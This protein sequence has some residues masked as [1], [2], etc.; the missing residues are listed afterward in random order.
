MRKEA[1]E[2]IKR[3]TQISVILD[4]VAIAASIPLAV[5]D[6]FS[7]ISRGQ[8]NGLLLLM[9]PFLPLFIA[10]DLAPGNLWVLGPNLWAML[11]AAVKWG[12]MAARGVAIRKKEA[13]AGERLDSYLSKS[14]AILAAVIFQI[15]ANVYMA[16]IMFKKKNAIAGEYSKWLVA[17]FV[18]ASSVLA[19]FYYLRLRKFEIGLKYMSEEE[20]ERLIS[21]INNKGDQQ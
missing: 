8:G 5:I 13:S 14:M 2:K 16:T 12:L 1:F 4:I 6:F 17:A 3:L 7:L 20:K 9:L 15:F 19:V 10:Y 11:T 21:E 18:I